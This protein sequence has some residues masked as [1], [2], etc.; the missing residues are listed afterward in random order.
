MIPK[1]YPYIPYIKKVILLISV[2]F[3]VRFF[4]VEL[5]GVRGYDGED[6]W[7]TL[8]GTILIVYLYGRREAK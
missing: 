6:F 5:G 3:V 1:I 7:Y 8:A 2:F 4:V